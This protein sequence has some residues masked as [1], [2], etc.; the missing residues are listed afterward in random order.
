V[1]V[2]TNRLPAGPAGPQTGLRQHSAIRKR[3]YEVPPQ[4]RIVYMI[5]YSLYFEFQGR[6]LFGLET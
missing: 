3:P 6:Y 4:T 1:D 2:L 5:V